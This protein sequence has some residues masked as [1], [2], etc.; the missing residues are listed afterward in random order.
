MLLVIEFLYCIS[1]LIFYFNK[2]VP[3]S[4]LSC[5]IGPQMKIKRRNELMKE[6]VSNEHA[7]ARWTARHAIH[8]KR[9]PWR[10][11]FL[12]P[13]L[14]TKVRRSQLHCEKTEPHRPIY[15]LEDLSSFALAYKPATYDITHISKSVSRQ[16]SYNQL[17][18]SIGSY[19]MICHTFVPRPW[20]RIL[21]WKWR[22]SK[23]LMWDFLGRIMGCFKKMGEQESA[24][25]HLVLSSKTISN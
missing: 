12:H 18:I 17:L 10:F 21:S 6:I 16:Q 4:H 9:T 3:Q 20:C 15:Q 2:V 8:V 13:S 19:F 24:N 22:I 14:C 11:N 25:V 5:R 7:V 1:K 23:F